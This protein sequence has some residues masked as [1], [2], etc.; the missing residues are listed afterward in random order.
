[1][2]VGWGAPEEGM[3][4]ERVVPKRTTMGNLVPKLHFWMHEAGHWLHTWDGDLDRLERF[5]SSFGE[6]YMR[7]LDMGFIA[8]GSALCALMGL[9]FG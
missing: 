1:M 3:E 4:C 8:L 5:A 6:S 9:M 2:H 7:K